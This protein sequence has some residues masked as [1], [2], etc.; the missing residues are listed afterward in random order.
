MQQHEINLEL[1]I[2]FKAKTW[3]SLSEH[4]RMLKVK[5]PGTS[6]ESSEEPVQD[7]PCEEGQKWQCLDIEIFTAIQNYRNRL[8]YHRA[9]RKICSFRAESTKGKVWK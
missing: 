6:G 4:H 8:R 2:C 3:R 7:C 1:K 5:D 9:I